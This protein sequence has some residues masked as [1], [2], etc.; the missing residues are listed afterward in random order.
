[1]IRARPSIGADISGVVLLGGTLRAQDFHRA[2]GR[3]VVSLPIDD[4]ET[5]WG[6]WTRCASALTSH[7]DRAPIRLDL[8]VGSAADAPELDTG[9][10][11]LPGAFVDRNDVRGSAGVLRDHVEHIGASGYVVIA[12]A[13]Q[14]VMGD[15]AALVR[16][17]ARVATDLAVMP[18]ADGSGGF[19]M[20]ARAQCLLGISSRGFIDLKEQALPALARQYDVRVVTA[21][22]GGGPT[23]VRSH[24]DY[25]RLLARLHAA[26][27]GEAPASLEDRFALR[28]RV[29]EQG[30]AVAP[31]AV[32]Q[33]SV[34]LR[35]GSVGAGA[36]AAWCVVPKGP[37]VPPGATV[38][39]RLVTA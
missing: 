4:D 25:L 15:F 33:N 18:S 8:L 30:A 12:N 29:V 3:P 20:I 28:F 34:V 38:R 35:G 2:L 21:P 39:N 36:V 27:A 14:V 37:G 24:G 11:V 23:S 19:L 13:N 10:R 26:P 9:E 17:M 32:V 22:P 5:V 1:V 6:R 31:D 16:D 7:N